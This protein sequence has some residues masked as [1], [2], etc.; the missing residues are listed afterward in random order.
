[1]VDAGLEF[2][3]NQHSYELFQGFESKNNSYEADKRNGNGM[4]LKSKTLR[5]ITYKPD[6]VGKDF[7]IETKGIASP[8]F[9]LRWKMFKKYLNDNNLKYD[10]FM[11]HNQ[12]Q[13]QECIKIIK[14]KQD[15]SRL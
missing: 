12:K 13:I 6:F 3:Y 1:L 2:E 11:P 7:I 8:D 10:L 14:E 4:Y 9:A 15:G 5:K